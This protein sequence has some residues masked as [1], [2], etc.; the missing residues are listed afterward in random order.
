MAGIR[1]PDRRLRVFVSSTLGELAEERQAVARAIS[2]LR[3]TAVM[4][5]QGARPQRPGEVYRAYL[6]QS[7]VFVGL[8]WQ[9]Y[10][11]LVPG[12]AVSGLAEEA[13]LSWG[14]PRL[15][16]LKVPAPDR[17]PRLA[18]L[19]GRL[20]EESSYRLF[21]TP[22]E[23][24]RLVRDDLAVLLS[25]GF[26]AGR[27]VATPA[28]P[29]RPSVTVPPLPVSTT[30]LVGREQEIENVAGLLLHAGRRLV[31]L[32]GPGGV[33][34]TR[35]ALAVADRLRDR[36]DAGTVFVPLDDVTEP[37]AAVPRI[38]WALGAD[39]AGATR[40]LA[41]LAELFGDDRWLVVLDNVERLVTGGPHL[42][43]LLARSPGVA[44]L[45]TSTTRLGVRAEHGYPVPPLPVPEDPDPAVAPDLLDSPAVA[46]FLERARAVRPGFVPTDDDLAAVV[47]ICRRLEGLPLAIELA[48]ARVQLLSPAAVLRRLSRSLDTLGRGMTDLPER[49]RTLR[50]TVEWS[51][52]MLGDA[53]RSL[54]EVL[55]VFSDGWTVEAAARVAGL[56][57]DRALELTEALARHS[58]LVLDP[59]PT[60]P[61]T[62]MMRTVRVY[63][64][65]RLAARPDAA[66]IRRRHAEYYRVLAE[67][68]D[69]ALRRFD[70][71][72]VA[73]ALARETGNITAAVRWHLAHD[74]D[75]VPHLLRVLSPFRILWPF[76]G[77]GDRLIGEARSWVTELVPRADD[78]PTTARAELWGAALVSALEVSDDESART[79]CR[80]LGAVLE[81]VE[82][83]Y[84][85]AVSQLLIAWTS[86]LLRDLAGARDDLN[87]ALARLQALDEPMWGALALIFCGSVESA[88]GDHERAQRCLAQARELAGRFDAPWLA[89]VSDVVFGALGIARGELAPARDSLA[90][91]LELSLAGQSTHCL[92]LVL[93]ATAALALAEGDAGRAAVLVGAADALRRRAA[94]RVWTAIRG[95]EDLTGTVRSAAG[96]EFAARFTEGGRLG[97]GEVV[98]LTRVTLG[99][100]AGAG[101]P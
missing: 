88:L 6:S 85:A 31:T 50:D 23:L 70:Q 14:M 79:A 18:E 44:V 78:L 25:E 63:V 99:A 47:E 77:L 65:Q 4:F 97:R 69:S 57:E 40:P 22:A 9:S 93:D 89:T 81:H 75:A 1:T 58:L 2:S 72:A 56:D 87:D 51:L 101:R 83:P 76:L 5:E 17:D 55:S 36:F 67:S 42:A 90:Q 38:A 26:A 35:L 98:D 16:Y 96:P 74:A 30:S 84:L 59:T 39:L 53:E 43:E 49:Q 45:A 3:L 13:E 71:R 12:A 32:T 61:R 8:Y 21:R 11:Q 28:A 73:E 10:G 95:D 7:D 62:R 64:A 19:I 24:G 86:V 100:R 29:G 15:L 91:A 54:L 92:G 68:A 52:G 41:A 66:E 37:V 82:D 80:R 20:G 27:A 33:G 94:L 48:A 46:L 60:G 34:K